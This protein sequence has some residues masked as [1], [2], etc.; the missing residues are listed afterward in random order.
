MLLSLE[1]VAGVRH[2]YLAIRQIFRRTLE[3][4]E[5][6]LALIVLDDVAAQRGEEVAAIY[7]THGD[8]KP[9]SP[10][11]PNSLTAYEFAASRML[12]PNGARRASGVHAATF[13]SQLRSL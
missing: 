5:L 2:E 13:T 3:E 6:G 10:T 12:S 7:G 1:H 11:S 4:R 9:V 8:D